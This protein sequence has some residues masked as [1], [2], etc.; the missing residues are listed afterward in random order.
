MHR[1]S[2]SNYDDRT[3]LFRKSE[4]ANSL[5]LRAAIIEK[6]FWVCWTLHRLFEVIGFRPHL[7]FK[8]GT[9]LSKVYKVIDRFSE[10]VDL[11]L[12]RSDLGFADDHDPEQEGIGKKEAKRRLAGLVDACKA[13]VREKLAPVLQNDFRS[14]LGSSGWAVELDPADP[15][16]VLFS[17]PVSEVSHELP[18]VRPV[19]R[20]EMGARS[21]D[22][23]ADD[24]GIKPYAAEVFP[25]VFDIPSA[26]VRT[27]AAE[28]TFWE[29]AT[30]LHAEAHRPP[31]KPDRERHARH[32]YDLAK[33]AE[34]PLGASALSRL[35]LLDRVIAHKTF[36][37]ASSWANYETARPGTL[38][39]LPDNIARLEG[40]RRDYDHMKS[41]V[42]GAVPTWDHI[43]GVLRDLE[44][45]INNRL[46]IETRSV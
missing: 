14:V 5:G 40:L 29:K 32:Y 33:L 27:L 25:E 22:W 15:Q 43:T 26:R 21:D 44:R 46:N 2:K 16:T 37:F 19:I 42:Y 31:D 36:F 12:S 13:V 8:G 1:L 4:M 17:Y 23:P 20:L 10:D 24:A 35:D 6:D 30:L 9:S 18:Y 45:R 38:R 7:I 3:L 11:S 34:H 41:M 28:R 39:L